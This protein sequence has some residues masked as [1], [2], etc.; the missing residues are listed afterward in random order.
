MNQSKSTISDPIIGKFN[1]SIGRD[2]DPFFPFD[3]KMHK[4]L[5]LLETLCASEVEITIY[6]S[7]PLVVLALPLLKSLRERLTVYILNDGPAL[8]SEL[9]Q[10]ATALK[11]FSIN[12]VIDTK[13]EAL[14]A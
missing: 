1:V 6:T 8:N 14:A 3:E 13:Q 2:T 9:M 10:A 7:S 11:K 4:T 5:R 12:T